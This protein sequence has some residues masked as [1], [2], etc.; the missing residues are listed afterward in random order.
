VVHNVEYPNQIN[1]SPVLGFVPQIGT[2]LDSFRWDH[3]NLRFDRTQAD[4][5]VTVLIFHHHIEIT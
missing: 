2:A 5:A 3:A 4:R 1:P